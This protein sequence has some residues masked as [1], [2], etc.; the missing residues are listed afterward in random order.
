MDYSGLTIFNGITNEEVEA[1][2]RCFHMRRGQY[3]VGEVIPRDDGEVGVILHG[4]ADLV[5]FDYD[6]NRT[7]LDRLETGGVFG[8]ALAFTPELGDFVETISS[9][10]SEILFMA[11]DHIM[12]RCEKACAYHSKLVQN[13]FRLLA[14]Q[15]KQLSRR[16][17]VLSRRSI[18]EKLVCYFR[19]C[20]LETGSNTFLLPFSL[21]ALAE[22][23]SNDRSAMM[24]EL[25][26]MRKEGMISSNGRQITLLK[27]P[28]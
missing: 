2:V 1:M 20:R 19:I 7:I 8:E 26:K 15:S 11:Y 16:V 25:Q 27:Q 28:W 14:E 10:S 13:M 18:R 23:I 5:R 4:S 17:D 12:K 22:Y 3:A 24:R 21:T 9:G 6:G